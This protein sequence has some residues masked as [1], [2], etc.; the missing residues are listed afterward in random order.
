MSLDDF[1]IADCQK[2]LDIFSKWP[3]PTWGFFVYATYSLSTTEGDDERPSTADMPAPIAPDARFQRV[4]DKLRAY[5][6]AQLLL[7]KPAPYGQ[8]I[9]DTLRLVPAA[10][11]PGASLDDVRAHFRTHIDEVSPEPHVREDKFGPGY[12]WCLVVDDESLASVEAGP[13]PLTELPEGTR[14]RK[15]TVAETGVWVR[16]V[17]VGWDGRP[18]VVAQM[19]RGKSGQIVW[20]GS[21]KVCPRAM[22][23]LWWRAWDG[24]VTKEFRG[25]DKVY[26]L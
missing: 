7:S 16:A 18:K 22:M 3:D 13:E 4:L 25:A 14:Y 9:L 26:D 17:H 12:S 24:E 23:K 1:E 11:L 21:L 2:F 19:G 10:R 5:A 15:A 8:R 6:S 20:E